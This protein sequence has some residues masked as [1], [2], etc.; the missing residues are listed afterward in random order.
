M[1]TDVDAGFVHEVIEAPDISRFRTF[2]RSTV[3]S[4]TDIAKGDER[5]HKS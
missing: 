4:G 1:S 3:Q 5:M 2:V